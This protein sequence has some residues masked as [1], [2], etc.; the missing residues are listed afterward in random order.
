MAMSRCLGATLFTTRPPI[1]TSPPEISS[2]PAIMRSKVDLP[3]PEG[4]TS[5]QN[6][7]SA[8]D[9]STPCTTCVEPK[10]LRTALSVTAA[11]DSVYLGVGNR[12]RAFEE[13]EVAALVRL[14]DVAR[15]D[16]AVAALVLRR[17]PL[18][19]LLARL[20][21]LFRDL[22]VQRLLVRVELDQVAGFHQRERPAHVRLGR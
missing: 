14:L 8:I 19:G 22:Q 12:R 6:S 20:E 4:P 11:M 3:Q 15:E 16:R 7:P 5:T 13:V 9:T 10:D 17:R 1:R 2:R 18:P 21:F